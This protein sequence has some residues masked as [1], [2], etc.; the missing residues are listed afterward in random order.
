LAIPS[1]RVV[2]ARQMSAAPYVDFGGECIWR[3][4]TRISLPPKAFLVVRCLMAQPNQLVTKHQ[5]LEAVWPDYLRRRQSTVSATGLPRRT[6]RSLLS[7]P[8]GRRT[9]VG[10]M[11]SN[12]KTNQ[13]HIRAVRG[14]S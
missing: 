5:L 6:R 2:D 13:N 9:F 8:R 12:L 11:Y 14:G 7:T 3:A 10:S 4:D 1:V